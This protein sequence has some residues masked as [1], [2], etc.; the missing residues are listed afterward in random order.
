MNIC[1]GGVIIFVIHTRIV[2]GI[3]HNKTIRA[4]LCAARTIDFIS[5]HKC[6]RTKRAHRSPRPPHATVVWWRTSLKLIKYSVVISG[7]HFASFL[8]LFFGL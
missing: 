3:S 2:H 7:C 6:A 8:L 1:G 5:M 4:N